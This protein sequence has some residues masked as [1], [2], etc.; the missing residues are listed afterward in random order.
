[1]NTDELFIDA[2]KLPTPLSKQEAYNLNVKIKQGDETA[3]GKLVEHNIRLVLST[4]TRRFKTVK[5]NKKD[6]VSIGIIGLM[7][8]MMTYGISKK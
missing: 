6:L 5:Y 7:K 8:A 4:V 1:M 2:D 3:K